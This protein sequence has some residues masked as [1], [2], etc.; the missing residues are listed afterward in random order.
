MKHVRRTLVIIACT[1]SLSAQSEVRSSCASGTTFGEG[2]TVL[3]KITP[4]NDLLLR[5]G[6]Q[7]NGKLVA[8]GRSQDGES[9]A[10]I[11]FILA[12]YNCEGSLDPSF[13]GNG[14]GL[15]VVNRGSRP[16]LNARDALVLNDDSILVAGD[17][18]QQIVITKFKSNGAWDSS[19]GSGG[20]VS[21]KFEAGGS[22]A[23]RLSGNAN[24]GKFIL[25][26]VSMDDTQS[27]N[28]GL[29]AFWSSNGASD[30][31]FG[32]HGKVTKDVG[33]VNR[34]HY[35][36]ANA[37]DAILVLFPGSDGLAYLAR[38][39]EQGVWDQS[40]GDSGK[41]ALPFGGPVGPEFTVD[42]SGKILVLGQSAY[43]GKDL[44][45]DLMATRFDDK[46]VL[47][48]SFGNAGAVQISA[49][50]CQYPAAVRTS[51][52]GSIYIGGFSD[53]NQPSNRSDFLAVKLD[54]S[55]KP[56]PTYGTN[57]FAYANLKHFP[58]GTGDNDTATSMVVNAD[59][60]VVI[61]GYSGSKESKLD[62]GLARFNASG[63]LD[64]P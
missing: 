9:G 30:V 56:D 3:T 62:F 61:G 19:F 44:C 2:G 49:E 38:F 26:G 12:R 34:G 20:F 42:A 46:G 22:F 31:N 13:G 54:S 5:L 37:H 35:R 47:D 16:Y 59:G 52:D 58:D 50:G 32:D 55:G 64:A 40:F 14:K 51:A 63:K 7:R 17:E 27:A 29:S 4:Y 41:K 10:P 18:N 36:L 6:S 21:F 57:G 25:A 33:S 1:L 45:Y 39:S 48:S 53:S 8:F 11:N 60:R 43:Q 24:P 15:V 23:E 28:L